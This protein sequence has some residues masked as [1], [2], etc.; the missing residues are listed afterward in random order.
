VG[1]PAVTQVVASPSADEQKKTFDA[2]E[3][4]FL[5]SKVYS[6]IKQKLVIEKERHGRHGFSWWT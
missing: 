1:G 2:S 6:Y 4:E 3:I 5:A